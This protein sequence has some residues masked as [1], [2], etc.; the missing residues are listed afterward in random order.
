MDPFLGIASPEK[1][2]DKPETMQYFINS[3]FN[4]DIQKEFI[5]HINRAAKLVRE[6]GPDACLPTGL[7]IFFTICPIDIGPTS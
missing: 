7:I 3:D 5:L 6:H 1:L 4:D 2:G